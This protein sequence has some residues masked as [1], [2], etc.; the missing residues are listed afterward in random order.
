MEKIIS[1]KTHSEVSISPDTQSII[2]AIKNRVRNNSLNLILPLE[3]TLALVDELAE[4][5]LGRFLLHNRG[6]NGYW[7]SYIFTQQCDS[8]K[9]HPLK[10]W[11]MEDSLLSQARERFHRFKCLLKSEI[12]TAKTFA[13]IPCGVMD[14]LLDQDYS[15]QSGIKIKGIDLDPESISHAKEK[16]K[17]VGLSNLCDFEIRDAWDLDYESVFDV[18]TSNGLNMYESVPERLIALYSNFAKALKPGGRLY[19]SFLTPPPQI[20]DAEW[21]KYGIPEEDLKREFSIFGD[22]LQATYLNFV[23]E[24]EIRHQ[25]QE[26]GLQVTDVFY[27][28]RGVLPVLKAVK[29]S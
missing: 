4:F 5:D 7:T 25:M 12:S 9:E 15:H 26:A 16:A 17:R 21:E 10:K 1:H 2:D 13:S 18:I 14:D 11:L 19:I 23:S 8:E 27:N 3:D 28:E 22:I 29:P 20:G 6:L 24:E